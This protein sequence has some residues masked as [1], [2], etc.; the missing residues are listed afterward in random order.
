MH[1]RLLP[2]ILKADETY[3]HEEGAANSYLG[4]H[5]LFVELGTLGGRFQS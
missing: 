2:W 4:V 1:P 5:S 3:P